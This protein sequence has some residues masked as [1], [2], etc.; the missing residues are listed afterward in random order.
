V[1]VHIDFESASD[2]DIKVGAAAYAEH[3]STRVLCLS[4]AVGD[5]D[6]CTWAP[7]EPIPADLWKH[8][9]QDVPFYAWNCLFEHAMWGR[10]MVPLGFPPIS[11]DR[12]RNTQAKAMLL[13]LPASLDGAAVALKM[14]EQKDAEGKRLML[15]M[16]K[17][18][19]GNLERLKVYC[20]QDV[21]TERALHARLGELPGREHAVYQ[22]D[23]RINTRGVP[24]DVAFAR[25]AAK[26]AADYQDTKATEM[27]RRF[28]INP[29]QVAKIGDK[30]RAMNVF[31]DDLTADTIDGILDTPMAAFYPQAAI[32]MLKL[33]QEAAAVSPKKYAAMLRAV[34]A[35]GRIR[36]MFQYCGALQ[37]GRW[38]GRVVQLHNL[39]RPDLRRPA[40]EQAMAALRAS[41]GAWGS[42]MD[43]GPVLSVLGDCVRPTIAP[44]SGV[45]KSDASQIEAR[46]LAWLANETAVLE[47]FKRGDDVYCTAASGIYGRRITK[48]DEEE[49]QIG[50]VAVLALGYGG[51]KGAFITMG[52]AYGVQVPEERAKEI[53]TAWRESNPA[54]VQLWADV[55]DAM[56]ICIFQPGLVR[57]V[58]R[59]RFIM[60]DGTLWCRLPSGRSLAWHGAYRVMRKPPW[61]DAD[62]EDPSKLRPVI[63][64]KRPFNSTMVTDYTRGAVA[65]ENICQAVSRD[66]LAESMVFAHRLPLFLHVHDELAAEGDCRDDL[67]EAMLRP[68]AWADG[69][70]RGAETDYMERYFKK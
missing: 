7:G 31:V 56:H 19:P 27:Q 52:R 10:H 58:G 50:K 44:A 59:L 37:T 21:R 36:G 64:Y 43:F 45:T 23:K 25:F 68:V 63:A 53:K 9:D 1:N 12:W 61:V 24:I 16:A 55:N 54:I 32:E 29:T 3:P 66:L 11:I 42:L 20:A 40:I 30:L 2:V 28:K 17:G 57:E 15:S 35:D 70:P 65:V 46:V 47:T 4:W 51:G 41:E 6:P 33:R 62:D 48:A 22:M 60:H 67:H 5:G 38:S 26:A 14:D 49:R 39:K 13:G 8:A 34:S 18:N 69:L